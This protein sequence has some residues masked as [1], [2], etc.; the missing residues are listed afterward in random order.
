MV[1]ITGT[2]LGDKMGKLTKRWT[3]VAETQL[4][5]KTISRVEY[6]GTEEC[7]KYGWYS[8]PITFIL[9]DNTRV[10]AMCDDE[11]NNGGVLT[12]LTSKSE[13]VLPVLG[14]NDK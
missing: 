2:Y 5:G 12:C 8:R 13:E 10:I 1:C 14:L 3:K 11:G 7:D 6:M 4:L 9:N